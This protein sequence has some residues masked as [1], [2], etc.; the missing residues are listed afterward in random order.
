M[1]KYDAVIIGS[2]MVGALTANLLLK[3][4]LNIALVDRADGYISLSTPPHF[5]TRVSAISRHSQSLFEQAEVWSLIDDARLTPYY[6][7]QVWDG[8]GTGEIQFGCDDLHLDSLGHLVENQILLKASL[9][10]LSMYSSQVTTYF[11]TNV[12]EIQQ[13][14]NQVSISLDSGAVLEASVLIAADGANSSIR[15]TVGI[16]TKEWD[17]N[18]HAL[19]ATIELDQ[20]HEHTAWQSFGEEGILAFLPMPSYENRHFVS[21]VWSVLPEDAEKLMALD[22]KAFCERLTYAIS[23]KFTVLGLQSDRL[24]IPLRQRHATQYVKR[25]V[26]LIGDAAHT[27]H[28][29]AGQG[30]NLGF[31]DAGA[32]SDVLGKA[33]QRGE[34]LADER[35]LRRYQRLRMANNIEM[36]ASMEFFKQLYGKQTPLQVLLRNVGLSFVNRQIWLKNHLVKLAIG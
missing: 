3:Q 11:S 2:G 24:S 15:N 32:L 21:I 27:I 26:A 6:Q 17:Y 30:A 36:A 4:G 22:E 34:N 33:K 1:L 5:D 28:P 8:L 35:V 31:A 29:L 23:S 12:T 10:R 9:E 20:S 18:H 19:V 13:Q 25:N 14:E 16:S 7:M